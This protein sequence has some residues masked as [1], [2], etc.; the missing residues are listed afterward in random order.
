MI[1][2]LFELES[3]RYPFY[4]VI[5]I[6]V[7]SNENG[8]ITYRV[9]IDSKFETGKWIKQEPT[10]TIR[11]SELVAEMRDEKIKKILE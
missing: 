6:D 1:D 2:Y 3:K 11:L 5:K 8:I 10:R 9:L 4:N 7:I